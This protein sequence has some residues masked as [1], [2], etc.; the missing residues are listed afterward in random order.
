VE[1]AT[2]QRAAQ[3][4]RLAQGSDRETRID[5]SVMARISATIRSSSAL[6]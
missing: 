2:W 3:R 6:P 5:P 4:D 1:H